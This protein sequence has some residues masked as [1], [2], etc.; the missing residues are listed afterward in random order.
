MAMPADS[1]TPQRDYLERKIHEYAHAAGIGIDELRWTHPAN[2]ER[3]ELLIRSG[4]HEKRYRLAETDDPPY[5][6]L[7]RLT[8]SDLDLLANTIVKGW[9]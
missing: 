8:T 7:S 9:Q 1:L 5:P 3:S 6:S 2:P 4:G